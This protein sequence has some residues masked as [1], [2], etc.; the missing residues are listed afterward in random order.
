MDRTIKFDNKSMANIAVEQIKLMGESLME[1][2]VSEHCS[3]VQGVYECFDI[4][5]IE[6]NGAGIEML[7]ET[8]LEA[9][10]I[11]VDGSNRASPN[12]NYDCT[13]TG[14]VLDKVKDFFARNFEDNYKKLGV[15]QIDFSTFSTNS[16]G[17]SVI[18]ITFRIV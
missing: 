3:N 12:P 14:T 2:K 15:Y 9:E 17:K 13:L 6:W 7:I 4:Q 10:Y 16:N 18:T 1:S 5:D 8:D 11:S